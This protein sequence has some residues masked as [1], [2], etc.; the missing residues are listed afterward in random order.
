M[1]KSKFQRIIRGMVFDMLEGK[2]TAPGSSTGGTLRGAPGTVSKGGFTLQDF[3]KVLGGVGGD[4]T[5]GKDAGG[6]GARGNVR[7]SK[8]S[9][10]KGGRNID[11]WRLSALQGGSNIDKKYRTAGKP[12]QTPTHGYMQT[13][14]KSKDVSANI[15][16]LAAVRKTD[17]DFQK[18]GGG[19]KTRVEGA[20]MKVSSTYINQKSAA[21]ATYESMIGDEQMRIKKQI[22]EIESDGG[23]GTI[24]W[25]A[26]LNLNEDIN[27]RRDEYIARWD[28]AV[29][30]YSGNQSAMN[31][32]RATIESAVDNRKHRAKEVGEGHYSKGGKA[33]PYDGRGQAI[34]AGDLVSG[35]G[36]APYPIGMEN[37]V[38]Q[39]IG[40]DTK[41]W[42]YVPPWEDNKGKAWKLI[43]QGK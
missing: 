21:I 13:K 12:D 1:K 16:S 20:Q 40:S 41:A 36:K 2:G 17:N 7:A 28:F 24:E 32:A 39:A 14:S 42:E 22:E 18:L 27:L 43:S 23:K 11:T 34:K 9:L 5:R 4:R 35:G 29:A 8:W 31:A 25:V 37:W 26:L 15:S 33:T 3:S 19:R 10:F 30:A 6:K 38:W